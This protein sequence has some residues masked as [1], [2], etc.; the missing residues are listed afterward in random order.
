MKRIHKKMITRNKAIK[1]Q[2]QEAIKMHMAILMTSF[3]IN[4]FN[5]KLLGL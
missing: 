4:D 1:N 5:S 2:F 3:T